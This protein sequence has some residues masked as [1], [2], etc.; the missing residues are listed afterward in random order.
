MQYRR[1]CIGFLKEHQ[2]WTGSGI[3]KTGWKKLK[4][5]EAKSTEAR[6]RWIHVEEV[7][8]L[9]RWMMRKRHVEEESAFIDVDLHFCL[10]AKATEEPRF[11]E[12]RWQTEVTSAEKSRKEGLPKAYI[13]ELFT[14]VVCQVG[15]SSAA[16]TPNAT[17]LH[18]KSTGSR[19]LAL[20]HAS[21]RCE[22]LHCS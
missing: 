15:A 3:R 9:F 2:W 18:T 1:K 4:C 17:R 10:C 19:K 14:A 20:Y 16:F 7:Q 11:G 22:L 6:C 13:F 12:I 5:L 8:W 21:P